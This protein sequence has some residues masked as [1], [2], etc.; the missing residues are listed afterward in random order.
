MRKACS[1]SALI[2]H[3]VRL[4]HIAL[5]LVAAGVADD[6]RADTVFV[7]IV[8]TTNTQIVACD[9]TGDV[10]WT[11]STVGCQ[12][13]VQTST[14]L[15]DGS[16]TTIESGV[17][18]SL[19]QSVWINVQE[20]PAYSPIF[21]QITGTNASSYIGSRV[22]LVG[23]VPISGWS[24]GG[25]VIAWCYVGED[26]MCRFGQMPDGVYVARLPCNSSPV[27]AVKFTSMRGAGTKLS[28]TVPAS[29]WFC[30]D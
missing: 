15:A 18:T 1:C 12:Y 9:V 3:L 5:L 2:N 7:R 23:N 26:L 11:N 16:W 17:S 10:V 30:Q 28:P 24:T 6:L 27:S 14:S 13:S 22:Y 21:V 20:D 29:E 8:S 25:T 4:S 19:T